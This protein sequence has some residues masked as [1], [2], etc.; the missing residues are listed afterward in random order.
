METENYLQFAIYSSSTEKL[1]RTHVITTR[2]PKSVP[3]GNS[4]TN[5]HRVIGKETLQPRMKAGH[6]PPA[7][8]LY[9]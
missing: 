1:N 9:V 2:A 5:H 7:A 3:T 8:L 4:L 6:P